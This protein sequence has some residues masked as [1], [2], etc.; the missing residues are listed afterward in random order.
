MYTPNI[1][2]ETEVRGSLLVYIPEP[3]VRGIS[4]SKLPM[5]EVEGS[6]FGIYTNFTAWVDFVNS[7]VFGIAFLNLELTRYR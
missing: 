3:K 4:T 1:L 6:L 2:P 7:S 5:T